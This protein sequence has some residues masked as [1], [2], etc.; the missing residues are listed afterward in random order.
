MILELH[1]CG[2]ILRRSH[3]LVPKLVGFYCKKSV[4]Q[5]NT[6]SDSFFSFA[7]V[8]CIICRTFC[9]EIKNT[10]SILPKCVCNFTRRWVVCVGSSLRHHHHTQHHHTQHHT[11]LGVKI[12]T[13]QTA[14]WVTKSGLSSPTAV[15]FKGWLTCLLFPARH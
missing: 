6:L 8:Y 7:L 2:Y 3:I 15:G 9:E 12:R 1:I 13:G 11:C 10:F 5:F 4:L 14:P